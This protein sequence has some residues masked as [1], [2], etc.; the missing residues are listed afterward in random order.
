MKWK[1]G[2]ESGKKPNTIMMVFFCDG[3]GDGENG[4]ANAAGDDDV[5]GHYTNAD[6]CL[7]LS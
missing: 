4:D 5:D 7:C 6:A 3:D 2:R 1:E